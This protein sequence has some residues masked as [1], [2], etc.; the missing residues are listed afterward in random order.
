MKH[1]WV[2]PLMGSIVEVHDE[3]WG[4]V[5]GRKVCECPSHPHHRYRVWA[6]R[7]SYAY[8][9][10]TRHKSKWTV[11]VEC[12]ICG[13]RSRTHWWEKRFTQVVCNRQEEEE[14]E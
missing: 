11:F 9:E 10:A 12:T 2:Q 8:T 14:R 1:K 6:R 7:Q 5:L 3:F 13:V 4:P